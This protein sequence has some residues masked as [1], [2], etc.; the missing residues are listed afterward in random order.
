MTKLF[1]L[2]HGF[3]SNIQSEEEIALRA[4]CL[5][6]A[7]LAEMQQHIVQKHQPPK[8]LARRFDPSPLRAGQTN[9]PVKFSVREMVDQS[10]FGTRR[11]G[12]VTEPNCPS[13]EVGCD[14]SAF[15]SDE[16]IELAAKTIC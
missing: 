2:R 15:P 12:Q 11:C 8:H 4:L 5:N 14:R 10:P 16:L 1:R 6:K 13:E 3:R 7:L 9:K